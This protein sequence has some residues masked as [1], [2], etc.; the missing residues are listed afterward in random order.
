MKKLLLALAIIT[1]CIAGLGSRDATAANLNNF[2]IEDYRIDYHLSRDTNGRS[3][4]KT[5]EAI[6]AIF[7]VTDQNHGLERAIPL[8]YD[9]HTVN[10][11]IEAV[12]G[13]EG[14]PLNYTTYEQNGN[15]VLRIGDADRYV[16]GKQVYNITYTQHDVTKNFGGM[17]DDEFYWDTNG[18]GW[19]VPISQFEAVL[20]IDN[21][22]QQ[23]LTGNR[24]CYIGAA[25]STLACTLQP[26]ASGYIATGSS[27]KPGENITLAIGFKAQTFAPYKQSVVEQLTALWVVVAFVTGAAGFGLIIWFIVRYHKRSN[28]TAEQRTII[29]EYLPP[30]DTSVAA[31][32]MIANKYGHLFSAQ[33]VDFAVRHY[34]RI[35]QT[36]EKK[37]YRHANYELEITKDIAS[38]KKEE[39]ELFNDIFDHP[40]VGARLDLETLRR[41]TAIGKRLMDNRTKLSDSIHN[42]YGLRARVPLE[43]KW[44]VRAGIYTLIPAI[45]LLSPGLLLASGTAF[46]CAFI[47]HPLTDKGLQLARHLKGLEMYM[48]VAEANRLRMLQSPEGAAKL[49]APIDTND[50][51]ELIKL[52]ERILPYAILLGIERDWNKQLGAYYESASQQPDWFTGNTAVFNAAVFSSAISNLNA[53]AAYSDPSNSSSG[54]S[55]GGG[56]SGGGG[57]GGGGGGW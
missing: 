45:L 12:T 6:T 33:L 52:Y 36:R 51:R 54:G 49:P 1:A 44:F 37:W 29:P 7:P 35:Y 28:R 23:A 15:K 42:E 14:R 46:L 47:L 5:T 20:H 50:K 10:L 39:Q 53:V 17:H 57:G 56:S 21:T 8:T 25:G 11:R 18:T 41:N 9:G 19:R 13:T 48:K 16:H 27:M 22:L 4:L 30:P 32:S 40:A 34:I 24:Q 38:L 43:T 2:S 31:A 55:G 26:S 3:T